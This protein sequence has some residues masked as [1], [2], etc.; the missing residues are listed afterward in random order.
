MSTRTRSGPPGNSK[1]A[2][3]ATPVPAGKDAVTRP[4][5][6]RTKLAIVL[7]AVSIGSMLVLGVFA[8]Q[9]AAGLLREISE[10]QLEALAESKS[11]DVVKVI[12]S[13]RDRVRLISSRTQLRLNVQAY[14]EQADPGVLPAT[15]RIIRDAQASTPD[16]VAL[17]LYPADGTVMAR[18][19]Q[20]DIEWP[21]NGRVGEPAASGV[22]YLGV[23]TD[24]GDALV[25]FEAPLVLDERTIGRIRVTF[26]GRDL[27]SVTQNYTGLGELGET[28]ITRRDRDGSVYSLNPLRHDP[29]HDLARPF[30]HDLAEPREGLIATVIGYRNEL[31]WTATREIPD[32]DW[33]LSVQLDE[34]EELV[35]VERL[36]ATMIDLGLA[37]SGF[38]ILGGTLLGMYLARPL[39][40][41]ADVVNRVQHGETQ[42]RADASAD[43]EIGQLARALNEIL[44]QQPP[45]TRPPP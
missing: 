12:E 4:V 33:R 42:L 38:A 31:V 39:R 19:G 7:I 3:F 15:Q 25:G 1:P 13:W 28:I 22:R 8:Y 5:D 26:N 18:A 2:C 41:L 24:W 29:E 10:R 6:I 40:K 11:R 14:N 23:R 34:N 45:G 21:E 44:D 27:Q 37:L 43:D 36:R 9:T 16:V 17:A 35:R 32:V 30:T 20:R